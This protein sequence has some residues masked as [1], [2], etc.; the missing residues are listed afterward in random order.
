MLRPRP[1]DRVKSEA[2]MVG[3][4]AEGGGIN[5]SWLSCRPCENAPVILWCC[6]PGSPFC[7]VWVPE[8]CVLG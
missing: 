8:P 5:E 7:Q 1:Q 3:L 2:V 4:Q 6:H